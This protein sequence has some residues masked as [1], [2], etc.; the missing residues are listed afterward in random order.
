MRR[1][2]ESREGATVDGPDGPP[3]RAPLADGLFRTLAEDSKQRA[4]AVVLSG[5][6]HDGAI[7]LKAVREHGGLTT[8]AMLLM[9]HIASLSGAGR[10]GARARP[11]AARGRPR[12]RSRR[13]RHRTRSSRA[14]TRSSSA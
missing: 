13:S 4:V 7:G 5:S 12:P 6:G 9:E 1:H 10:S 3:R 11:P 14:R 2:G 8:I